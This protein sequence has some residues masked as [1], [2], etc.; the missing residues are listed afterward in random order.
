MAMGTEGLEGSSGWH[1]MSKARWV[2]VL[3]R[4]Q[5]RTTPR[6]PSLSRRIRMLPWERPQ[7]GEG[8]PCGEGKLGNDRI[9]TPKRTSNLEETDSMTHAG[10][11]FSTASSDEKG[12]KEDKIIGRGVPLS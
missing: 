7:G 8:Q 3:T 5:P 2:L 11:V 10:S 12:R 1:A 6:Q 9:F 4:T